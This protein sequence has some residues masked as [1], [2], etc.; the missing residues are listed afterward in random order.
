[1]PPRRATVEVVVLGLGPAGRALASACAAR[2]LAVTAV[3][4]RPELPWRAIYG[5]W[6]DELPAAVPLAATVQRPLTWTTRAQYLDRP[7]CVLDTPA[8]QRSMDLSRVHVH[9]ARAAADGRAL[10]DGTPLTARVVIDARGAPARGRTQQTAYGVLVGGAEAEP[11]LQG[12]AAVFMDWRA[13]RG[14]CTPS[15]LYAVPLG[16]DRVLLEETC[17]ARRPGLAFEE[18]AGRLRTRLAAHGVRLGG[19]EQVERVRFAL[20]TPLPPREWLGATPGVVRFGAAAPLV[21]PASGYSVAAALRL[22][23]AM[24]DVLAAGGTAADLQR[25]LWSARARAV[26]AIRLRG[27]RSLLAL[28]PEQVPEFFAAFFALP[29]RDQ[30]AYLS[31]RDDLAGT[32]GAMRA[33]LPRMPAQLSARVVRAALLG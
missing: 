21:H 12:A 24:A 9:A 31:G 19:D 14:H 7:Y 6:Q 4:P 18:L 13:D 20:D 30:R 10:D 3:D 23:P 32:A 27:M 16:D 26:H 28:S 17:L 22:A 8:L 11:L 25:L 1:M 15:F 33:V 2:G 29:T 5:A